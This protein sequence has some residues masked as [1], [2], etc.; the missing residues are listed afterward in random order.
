MLEILAK[1]ETLKQPAKKGTNVGLKYLQGLR[2]FVVCVCL[3]TVISAFSLTILRNTMS[4][5]T[6][7]DCK[8]ELVECRDGFLLALYFLKGCCFPQQ[9]SEAGGSVVRC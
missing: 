8:V 2:T 6:F 1:A 3:V 7:K 5:T 4:L 9:L